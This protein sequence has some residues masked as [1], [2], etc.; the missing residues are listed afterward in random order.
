MLFMKRTTSYLASRLSTNIITAG[1]Q[2]LTREWW[3]QER[4]HYRL[5]VSQAVL[6]ECGGGDTEQAK[7]RLSIIRT[8]P[9]LQINNTVAALSATYMNLLGIPSSAAM[10]AIHLAISV[11]H[12]VDYMLTWN[13]RH[14]A[15]GE[16]R[17]KLHRYNAANG[18]HEPMIVTPQ[19]L[20]G[21]H[22]IS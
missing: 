3:E 16:T 19:E 1:Q 2:I 13:C 6:D 14:L 18:L 11:A 8:L 22:D 12:N 20:E 15:H 9:L 4:H 17:L 21:N 7:K 5:H 10:D